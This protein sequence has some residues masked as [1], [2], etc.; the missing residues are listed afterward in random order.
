MRI[1]LKEFPWNRTSYVRGDGWLRLEP[2]LRLFH[3]T[4]QSV[5]IDSFIDRLNRATN[6]SYSTVLSPWLK[7]FRLRN[8]VWMA[9]VDEHQMCLGCLSAIGCTS[10]TVPKVL[11]VRPCSIFI[12]QRRR[13]CCEWVSPWSSFPEQIPFY[14]S[15]ASALYASLHDCNSERFNR[16]QPSTDT[17]LSC[18]CPI[19][20]IPHDVWVFWAQVDTMELPR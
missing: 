17:T 6:P 10:L 1:R 18:V 15:S 12:P 5:P 16:I 19:A 4:T 2:Y 7:R 3:F 13:H 11:I 9:T 8:R 20:E 14:E